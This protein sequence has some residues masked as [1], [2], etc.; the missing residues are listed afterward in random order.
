MI[1]SLQK[2][3]IPSEGSNSGVPNAPINHLHESELITKTDRMKVTVGMKGIQFVS[4]ESNGKVVNISTSF[5]VGAVALYS[6]DKEEVGEEIIEDFQILTA[7]ESEKEI[8]ET[9]ESMEEECKTF[10]EITI[11]L[12]S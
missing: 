6:V 3:H 4:V 7:D 10:S 8:D 1:F 5:G 2:E 9:L 12:F 11:S